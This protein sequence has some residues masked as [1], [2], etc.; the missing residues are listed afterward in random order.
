M[1]W[2]WNTAGWKSRIVPLAQM[3]RGQPI[4][5]RKSQPFAFLASR[6]YISRKKVMV[7]LSGIARKRWIMERIAQIVSTAWDY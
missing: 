4:L 7:G 2:S 5:R 3:P 1:N 6:R